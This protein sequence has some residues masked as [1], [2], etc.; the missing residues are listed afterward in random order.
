MA[1]YIIQSER[2]DD[3]KIRF[4]PRIALAGACVA[5]LG[6]ALADDTQQTTSEDHDHSPHHATDEIEEVVVRATPLRR[7]LRM[8][9]P[10]TR[11]SGSFIVTISRPTFAA[12]S[13]STQGGVLPW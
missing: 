8:P 10:L 4:V 5:A 1:E 7:N 3:M 12:S 11:G 13:A 2:D 9:R 6:S